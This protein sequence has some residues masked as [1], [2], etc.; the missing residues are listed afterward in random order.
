MIVKGEKVNKSHDTVNGG[1]H[2]GL[3]VQPEAGIATPQRNG[4]S[5]EEVMVVTSSGVQWHGGFALQSFFL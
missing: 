3:P 4:H 5:V 1:G 2:G